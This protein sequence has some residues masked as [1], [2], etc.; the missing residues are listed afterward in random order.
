MHICV[1]VYGTHTCVLQNQIY[2]KKQTTNFALKI[3][4][5]QHNTSEARQCAA[6]IERAVEWV[7][8]RVCVGVSV[9]VDANRW[10]GHEC[11]FM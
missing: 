4:Y 3:E 8:L 11:T 9:D 1:C 6:F 7:W 10:G 5:K 2:K